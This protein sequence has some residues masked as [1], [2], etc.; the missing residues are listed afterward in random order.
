VSESDDADLARR[1]ASGSESAFETLVER[2]RSRVFGTASRFARG[3]PELDDLA[4]EIFLRVWKGL[5][6]FRRDA[7]FEHWFMRIAVR[8]CYDHLRK[9]RRRREAEVLCD[10]TPPPPEG[11]SP[12]QDIRRRREAWELVQRLMTCLSDKDQLLITLIDL[13]ERSVKE[14]A[15]LT[16]WSESNVKV[17]AH[18]AR[19]RMRKY[20]QELTG[21]HER[22]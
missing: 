5:G 1:A 20:H 16:G 22:I 2:Y 15:A 21:N 12:G 8:T 19:K 11:D 6:S 7:P 4:Q 14:T 17:R 3:K 13:E 18:R 10:E 9:H